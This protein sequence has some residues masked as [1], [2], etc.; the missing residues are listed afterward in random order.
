MP[1]LAVEISDS[2]LT[3]TILS[4]GGLSI[5]VILLLLKFHAQIGAYIRKEAGTKEEPAERR[6]GP[7]PFVVSQERRMATH[8][9]LIAIKERAEKLD[10]DL[11]EIRSEIHKGTVALQL[12]GSRRAATIHRRVDDLAITVAKIE[13]R[14]ETQ[15][16]QQTQ[17]DAKMDRVLERLKA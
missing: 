4:G 13:E 5:G 3:A 11:A 10:K 16:H 17:L 9:E 14:S 7:Q 15:A 1:F 12:E 8:E 6:I 2:V